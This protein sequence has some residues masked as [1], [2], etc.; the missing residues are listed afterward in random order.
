MS[1]ATIMPAARLRHSWP[2]LAA[3]M[4]AGPAAAAD[5]VGAFGNLLLRNPYADPADG[6]FGRA[7]SAAISTTT[8][9]TTWRS[10]RAAA[11]ACASRSA[12][13][14]RCR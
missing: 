14:G 1:I 3:A 7:S 2:W 5:Q 9:S 8:A 4:L 6:N 13:R 10:P 11:R 12:P